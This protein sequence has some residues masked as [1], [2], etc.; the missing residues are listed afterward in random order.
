MGYAQ[1]QSIAPGSLD[2]ICAGSDRSPGE[3]AVSYFVLH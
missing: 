1:V 2:P 3:T